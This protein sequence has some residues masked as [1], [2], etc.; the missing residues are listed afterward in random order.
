MH[1]LDCYCCFYKKFVTDDLIESETKNG[2]A[3]ALYAQ[4]IPPFLP[5]ETLNA[6]VEFR[7]ANKKSRSPVHY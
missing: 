5:S 4:R 7:N 3:N 2:E 1:L 6:R